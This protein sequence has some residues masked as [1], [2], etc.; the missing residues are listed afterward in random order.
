MPRRDPNTGKFVSGSRPDFDRFTSVRATL[1]ATIP[2][3]D[4]AGGTG[5]NKVEGEES[6]LIDFNNELDADELF[7]PWQFH[8]VVSHQLPTTATAESSSQLDWVFMT[9]LDDLRPNAGSVFYGAGPIV[10]DGISDIRAAE[11]FDASILWGGKMG[12]EAGHS[13]TV[14]GLAGGAN[15]GYDSM[16]LDALAMGSP[17]SFD[18]DDELAVPHD[19]QFDNISDH[20]VQTAFTVVAHGGIVED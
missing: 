10:E 16:T 6:Q 20:A 18:E 1:D 12:A 17:W 3:A 9:D 15:H 14:N 4:L 7:I 13:D 8:F 2:A 11:S 5:T 19:V